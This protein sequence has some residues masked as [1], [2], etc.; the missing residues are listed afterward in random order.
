MCA[1]SKIGEEA[2]ELEEGQG[3]LGA[4]GADDAGE[5]GDDE[6]PGRRGEVREILSDV[7]RLSG[8]GHDILNPI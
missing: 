4:H 8:S 5:G 1:P 7:A 3:D 2:N 6:Q